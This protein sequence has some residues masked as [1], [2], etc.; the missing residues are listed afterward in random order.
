MLSTKLFTSERVC[1]QL[2]SNLVSKFKA[3]FCSVQIVTTAP[4]TIIQLS[5][6]KFPFSLSRFSIKT[7]VINENLNKNAYSS[8]QHGS[9]LNKHL[10]NIFPEAVLFLGDCIYVLHQVLFYRPQLQ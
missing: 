10:P 3:I 7:P 2:K 8:I 6:E 5:F 4:L 1:Y 9:T